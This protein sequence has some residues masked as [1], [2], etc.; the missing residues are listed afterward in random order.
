MV[1]GTT[2]E[3]VLRDQEGVQIMHILGKN[4]AYFLKCKEAAEKAGIQPP[5]QEVITFTNFVR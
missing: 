2:P 4:M 5:E 1:H 3:E